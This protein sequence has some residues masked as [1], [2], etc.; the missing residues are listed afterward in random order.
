MIAVHARTTT[1]A[2]S[3]VMRVSLARR[4]SPPRQKN[5]A[6]SHSRTSISQLVRWWVMA[7]PPRHTCTAISSRQGRSSSESNAR[8]SRYSAAIS[9]AIA[10]VW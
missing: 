4:S 8:T 9:I 5:S 1:V 7:R 3:A 2:S 10:T 6:S